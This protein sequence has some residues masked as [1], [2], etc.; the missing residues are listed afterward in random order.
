MKFVLVAVAA[1]MAAPAVG[2]ETAVCGEVDLSGL[3]NKD[4]PLI[5]VLTQTTLRCAT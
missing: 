2:A 3:E 1:L 5:P 4:C